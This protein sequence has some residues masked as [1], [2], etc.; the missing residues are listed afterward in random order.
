MRIPVVVLTVILVSVL[1]AVA[2]PKVTGQVQVRARMAH[3]GVSSGR[4][5]LIGVLEVAAIVGLLLRLVWPP[6]GVAAAVGLVLQMIGAVMFHARA[7]GAFPVV[8]VPMVFAVV[9]AALA[10]LHVLDG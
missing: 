3:L 5:R 2:V 7:K 10:I 6:L 1:L 4:T 8:V 9:A